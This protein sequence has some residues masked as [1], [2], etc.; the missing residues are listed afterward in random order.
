VSRIWDWKEIAMVGLESSSVPYT[1][2]S[3]AKWH[4]DRSSEKHNKRERYRK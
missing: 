2:R 4:T 1:R 3:T